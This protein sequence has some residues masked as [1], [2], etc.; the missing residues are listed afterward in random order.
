MAGEFVADHI[1]PLNWTIA[2]QDYNVASIL[3]SIK[4]FYNGVWLVIYI[5]WT[6]S[7]VYFYSIRD[8]DLL[9]SSDKVLSLRRQFSFFPQPDSTVLYINFHKALLLD[10]TNTFC[11]VY[12]NESTFYSS[13]SYSD[14]CE[15]IQ[16]YKTIVK[17]RFIS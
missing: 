7:I 14:K 2:P 10:R 6:K 1:S 11:M 9:P 8:L 5:R 15:W 13:S 3:F 4:G 12:I 17:N 16:Y